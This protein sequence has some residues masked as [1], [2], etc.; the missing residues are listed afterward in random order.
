MNRPA[1]AIPENA[2]RS[3]KT[4]DAAMGTTA[5]PAD[6]ER[7]ASR[8][9]RVAEELRTFWIDLCLEL[10]RCESPSEDPASQQPVLDLLA[11]RLRDLDMASR[12]WS[13]SRSGGGLLARPTARHRR[14]PMQLLIGHCDTVWPAGTLE[15]MPAVRDGRLLRGPGIYDMKAGLAQIVTALEIVRRLGI[16]PELTPVVFV[17]SDEEIGSHD[18]RGHL[19]RLARAAQRV[20]VLEPSLGPE[21]RVK[22]ARKGVGRFTLRARGRA[23]HAGLDPEQGASAILELS[24]VIQQLFSLNDP[25]RGISVNVGTIDGGLRSNVVAAESSAD[26]D[27]RVPALEDARAVERAIRGLEPTVPGVSLH[28][29][30]GFGRPPLEPT[31]RN[32]RL[33]H[34]ARRT[35]AAL[36]LELQEATAGGGSD[37]NL[38]SPW[39]AT[40]D[41]LGAVGAGA[42]A[43]HEHVDVDRSLERVALLALL[44]LEPAEPAA[45]D[46]ETAEDP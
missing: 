1:V 32:R 43:R 45:V 21:G 37:G 5:V 7:L 44:I 24:H 15:E 6:L 46:S 38:T 8:V 13:G 29:E 19:R 33:W 36:G 34:L 39:A 4:S 27:V 31:P 9:Q 3:L 25:E 14:A 40:L 17:D 20:W 16:R 30:G 22:T 41:G 26:V 12:R 10:T 35:A 18:A 2:K 23:A 28:V 11:D 42:H